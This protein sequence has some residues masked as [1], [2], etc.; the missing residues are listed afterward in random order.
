LSCEE[1]LVF[2]LGEALSQASQGFVFDSEV[3]VGV[4]T[5]NK[6]DVEAGTGDL[7]LEESKQSSSECLGGDFISEGDVGFREGIR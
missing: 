5:E 4:S 7:P 1:T 3:L 6:L 2:F